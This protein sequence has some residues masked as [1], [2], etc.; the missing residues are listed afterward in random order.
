MLHCTILAV[1]NGC[2]GT[3]TNMWSCCSSSNQCGENEGDCDVD[4]DCLGNLKCGT[5]NCIG[6]NFQNPGA[7]C[8]YQ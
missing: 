5:N 6:T 8:C 3:Q 1:E 7:D 2:D 4:S